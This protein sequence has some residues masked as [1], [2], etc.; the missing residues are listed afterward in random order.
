MI[1]ITIWVKVAVI[2]VGVL[3]SVTIISVFKVLW[4]GYVLKRRRGEFKRR[5]R[6]ES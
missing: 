4:D 1:E 6:P 2:V 3:A 5:Y